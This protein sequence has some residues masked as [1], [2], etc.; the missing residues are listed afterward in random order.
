LVSGSYAG[1][2]SAGFKLH[3]S[4][5]LIVD[6][7]LPRG[8]GTPVREDS[9]EKQVRAILMD[10][11]RFRS[12]RE[13]D[14]IAELARLIAQA[15]TQ[16]ESAPSD[17]RLRQETVSVDY[18]ETPELPPAP[19]LAVDLND[20]D[21]SCEHDEHRS[22]DQA[23]GVDD[24]LSAAEQQ[25]QDSEF[26]HDPERRGGEIP[27]YPVEEEHQDCEALRVRRHRLTLAM[28]I[29]LFRH[30]LTGGASRLLA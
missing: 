4:L 17:N 1:D 19:Q 28:A 27:H 5:K 30:C 12:D 25:Y 20:D 7:G 8:R 9:G 23:C 11:K 22:D 15:D 16:E 13:R 3:Y 2:F 21:Q 10:D 6:V 14:P 26:P 24:D 29:R 18:E